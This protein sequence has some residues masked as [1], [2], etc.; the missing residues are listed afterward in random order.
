MLNKNLNNIYLWSLFKLY[1]YHIGS[2]IK[3]NQKYL[4]KTIVSKLTCPKWHFG[5]VGHGGKKP[6]GGAF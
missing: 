6:I 4:I 1:Y 3:T 5:Q 2:I